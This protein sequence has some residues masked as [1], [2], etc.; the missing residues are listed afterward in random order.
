MVVDA[1]KDKPRGAK[2]KGSAFWLSFVAVV[3]ST[4]LSAL[5]LTAVSTALPTI[6]DSLHDGDDFVWVGSAYVLSSTAFLPL[7]GHLADVFGR[8]LTMLISIVFFA[9]G[10]ALAGTAQSMNMLIAA[11]TIQGIGGGRIINLAE[12]IMS[13][14]VP[15][16]ERGLY[17][18]ILGMTWSFASG[19]GPPIGGALAARGAWRWLFYLNL[20]VTGI[21]FALVMVFLQ[22][23]T[24]TGSA[25]DK[26][27][28]VDWL[29]NCI[30]MAGATLAMIGL[31]WA[32]VRYPWDSA[33]V[34][35]PLIIGFTL[36][37]TFFVYELKVPTEPTIPFEILRNRTSLGGFLATLSHG[38]TS[39]SMIYFMPVYFQACCG[40]SPLTAGVDMLSTGLVIA[41]WAL[42]CG[43][44]ISILKKYRPA[45]ILG[46][47]FMIVGFGLLSTL[48]ADSSLGAWVGFQFIIS[49]GIGIYYP[50]TIFPILAP[51][52]VSY[53]AA[54]LAFLAYLCS[55]G[56]TWG[57]TIA[58]TILQNQ[59]KTKLPESFASQFPEGVS[60]AYA[61]IPELHKLDGSLLNEVRV[62]FAESLAVIWQT[63]I[64]IS[65]LGGIALLLMKE[66]L[67][68]DFADENYGL[69]VSKESADEKTASKDDEAPR[70]VT[71]VEV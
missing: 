40:A 26:L 2:G 30:I 21:A 33:K 55:F 32:G 44:S 28:K 5:D 61:A 19:I 59:L 49:A 56:Q 14:L 60:I 41:P 52:P 23:R 64:G 34:L 62:A 53:T 57:I 31:T 47:I 25:R 65:V 8:H 70:N 17:Q 36:I 67:M 35:T 12:T 69:V 29:G 71:V 15:L 18:G 54:M 9:L 51:L 7:C 42:A 16:A 1:E 6:T 50:G 45:L 48:K 68:S 11:R 37:I 3:V 22:V 20:P 46:W 63:M 43:A 27:A 24:P 4:F 38:I 13:D 10:S 66:I 39:I 58:S